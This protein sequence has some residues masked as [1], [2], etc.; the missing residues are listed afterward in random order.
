MSNTAI[1]LENVQRLV[2]STRYISHYVHF[3][4]SHV[5]CMAM[6]IRVSVA[7]IPH[8]HGEAGGARH[9]VPLQSPAQA[10]VRLPAPPQRGWAVWLAASGCLAG[11]SGHLA[12]RVPAG[13]CERVFGSCSPRLH[14]AKA[15]LWKERTAGNGSGGTSGAVV[16]A[17]ETQVSGCKVQFGCLVQ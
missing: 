13:L 17:G 8:N 16:L 10:A 12:A 1:N 9:R 11:T 7:G 2:Y 4:H 6:A 15:V 3:V 14:P 5:S